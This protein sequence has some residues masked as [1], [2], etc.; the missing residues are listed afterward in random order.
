ML[1]LSAIILDFI[2]RHFTI[3]HQLGLNQ[4]SKNRKMAYSSDAIQAIHKKYGYE[5]EMVRNEMH[6]LDDR[7]S[8]EYLDL[9]AD[10]KSLQNQEEME[11]KR[12]EEESTQYQTHIDKENDQL[13]SQLAAIDADMESF[14]STR[15]EDI[16]ESFACFQR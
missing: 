14:K 11:V 1:S 8:D 13:E 12:I 7:T 16:K 4:E 2:A 10:L 9:M 15:S 3:E 5:E 6:S